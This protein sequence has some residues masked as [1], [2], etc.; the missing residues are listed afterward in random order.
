MF[1]LYLASTQLYYTVWPAISSI[2]G[3]IIIYRGG[4]KTLG[5]E[6]KKSGTL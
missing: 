2:I 3:G 6:R 1:A 4:S 5:D